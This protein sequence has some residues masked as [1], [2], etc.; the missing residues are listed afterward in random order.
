MTRQEV[1]AKKR[2]R[3]A[4]T[5]DGTVPLLRGIRSTDAGTV[6]RWITGRKED[7][8]MIALPCRDGRGS[9]HSSASRIL[10]NQSPPDSFATGLLAAT[11]TSSTHS[12]GISFRK[13][14]GWQGSNWP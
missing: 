7:P 12:G 6:G 2:G 1:L 3:Y 4:R 5:G 14:D 13:G 11:T 8:L 9:F 10:A